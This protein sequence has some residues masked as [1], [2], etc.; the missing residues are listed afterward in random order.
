VS[1]SSF[2]WTVVSQEKTCLVLWL[3]KVCM[4]VPVLGGDPGAGGA[5]SPCL[6]RASV[7]GH[8]ADR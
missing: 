2:S 1:I 8:V 3:F 7:L 4:C 6:G 5:C